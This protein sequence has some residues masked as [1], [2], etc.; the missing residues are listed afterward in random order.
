MILFQLS[1]AL[2]LAAWS[3][4]LGWGGGY[5]IRIM[6]GLVFESE[7]WLDMNMALQLLLFLAMAHLYVF[8][9]HTV[10]W[11]TFV[12]AGTTARDVRAALR[13]TLACV[14]VLFVVVCLVLLAIFIFAMLSGRDW[15]TMQEGF[16]EGRQREHEALPVPV[17]NWFR[18]GLMVLLAPVAEELLFRGGLYAAL[19]RRRPAWQANLLSSAVFAVM[20]GYLFSLGD[21]LVIGVMSAVVYERTRSLRASVIFHMYWNALAASQAMQSWAFAVCVLVIGVIGY[22]WSSRRLACSSA[23]PGGGSRSQ[24]WSTIWMVYAWLFGALTLISYFGIEEW[25]H[26]LTELPLVWCVFMYVYQRPCGPI[27]A[28]RVYTAVY[29]VKSGWDILSQFVPG[30]LVDQTLQQAA[31]SSD[32]LNATAVGVILNVGFWVV[33]WVPALVVLLRVS[34]VPGVRSLPMRKSVPHQPPLL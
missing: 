11:S 31:T 13:H 8:R 23:A 10:R 18:V 15:Q 24:G 12:P 27:V 25:W 4:V 7:V 28:W 1:F 26:M 2:S 16:L 33:F 19:R 14:G 29:V 9:L 22:L 32:V 34:R 6:T 3:A 20:H 21:V 5:G 30:A 17:G